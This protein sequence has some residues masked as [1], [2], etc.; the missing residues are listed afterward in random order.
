[1]K[2]DDNKDSP[3]DQCTKRRT[4]ESSQKLGEEEILCTCKDP[5]KKL[6]DSWIKRRGVHDTCL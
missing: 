3:E 5:P 6:L 1:M 2:D 4:Q